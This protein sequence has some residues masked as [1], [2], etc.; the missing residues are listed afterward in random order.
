MYKMHLMWE[1]PAVLGKHH[2]LTVVYAVPVTQ[3]QIAI[4]VKVTT[5]LNG[6]KIVWY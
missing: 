2:P 5:F 4:V 6:G 3:K 1:V